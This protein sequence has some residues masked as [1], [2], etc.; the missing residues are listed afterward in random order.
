MKMLI[1]GI[2]LLVSCDKEPLQKEIDPC[3]ICVE[4]TRRGTTPVKTREFRE[5]DP[6]AIYHMEHAHIVWVVE[7]NVYTTITTCK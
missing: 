1:L 6:V 2:L 5:C 4:I 7:Q 3:K